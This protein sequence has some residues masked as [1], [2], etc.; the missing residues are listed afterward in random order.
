MTITLHWDEV[1]MKAPGSEREV[2]VTVTWGPKLGLGPN[3]R[4]KR[5]TTTGSLMDDGW[6]LDLGL[7][8]RTGKLDPKKDS[9]ES[10]DVVAWVDMPEPWTGDRR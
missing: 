9:L 7:L 1:C 3:A 8:Q 10:M 5:A 2:F 4:T 6:H